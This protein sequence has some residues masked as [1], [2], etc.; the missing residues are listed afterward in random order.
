M[1]GIGGGLVIVPALLFLFAQ[2]GFSPEYLTQMAIGSSLATIVLTSLSAVWAHHR[3]QA[4]R[5]QLVKNMAA[6][7][8][9]GAAG[10]ALLATCIPGHSLEQLFAVFLLIVSGRMLFSTKQHSNKRL[11]GRFIQALMGLLIGTLSSILG[12]GGGTM[13]VPLLHHYSLTMREAVATASAC[14]FPI[15]L[16]AT[17]GFLGFGWNLDS[18]PAGSAGYLYLPAVLLISISSVA[19]APAGAYLAHR[20]PVAMLKRIFALLLLPVALRLAGFF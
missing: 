18:L 14:G 20:L 15:A 3:R 4:V 13:S 8:L 1:L 6:G 7:L 5:W 12:V 16:A 2:A 19:F 9:P 10:G 17:L 11:P